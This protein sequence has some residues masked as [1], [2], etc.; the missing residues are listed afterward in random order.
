M[1][2]SPSLTKK[3]KIFC[4]SKIS[5]SKII[6]AWNFIYP[7]NK[8]LITKTDSLDIIIKK[9]DEKISLVTH[10]KRA[11][12][13]WID[14]IKSLARKINNYGILNDMKD[15][16]KKD[17]RPSQPKE[18]VKNPTEWLSNYD[19]DK[20]LHQ[21]DKI[22]ENNYKFLGVFPIDFGLKDKNGSCLIDSKCVINIKQLI[23]HNIKYIGF[24][25]NLSR[26]N[27][28]GTHWTSSFFV[29]DPDIPSFGGYYYDSTSGDIP[30]DL[31]I[32][33]SDIKKQTEKIFKKPFK[34]YT[35]K[36]IHQKS[37]TECGMF[38][39]AFQTRWVLLLK[40]D[41][42]TVFSDII[43]YSGYTDNVMKYLRNKFFRPNISYLKNSEKQ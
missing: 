34:I 37:N 6:K 35:S 40:K 38:S 28:P 9:I 18:W 15:I 1:Y 5:L 11:Y 8:I 19:I 14:I 43:K 39:I 7:N 3:E 30:V 42:N 32:V 36:I 24:I 27:E 22:P 12:W 4:Y 20:V 21:Y 31:R 26:S 13:A 33:F 25:T 2:C 29:L 41:K 16:E 17:L 23:N 10:K